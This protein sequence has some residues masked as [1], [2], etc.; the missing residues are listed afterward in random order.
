MGLHEPRS[1][2]RASSR[3]SGSTLKSQVEKDRARLISVPTH[4]CKIQLNLPSHS[5]TLWLCSGVSQ[6]P[7]AK[8]NVLSSVA[9]SPQRGPRGAQ[10]AHCLYRSA[11]KEIGDVGSHLTFQ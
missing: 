6:K 1:G 9:P 5:Q 3:V 8:A 10:D 11:R 7:L 2:N 4:L